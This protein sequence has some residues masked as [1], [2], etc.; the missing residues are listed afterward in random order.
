[1]KKLV[2]L[3]GAFALIGCGEKNE[4][5][6][7]AADND[8]VAGNGVVSES[9]EAPASPGSG[10]IGYWRVDA[11]STFKEWEENPPVADFDAAFWKESFAEDEDFQTGTLQFLADGKVLLHGIHGESGSYAIKAS[12]ND[13]TD[14]EVAMEM[15][16]SGRSKLFFSPIENTLT[17]GPDLQLPVE[18]RGPP[19]VSIR[20]DETEAKE[21]IEKLTE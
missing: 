9:E 3:L 19:V 20:I 7:G 1:M 16:F 2:L 11:E 18:R 4:S 12:D 15:E 8:E 6:V 17:L 5:G 13:S 21:R 10:L 14:F